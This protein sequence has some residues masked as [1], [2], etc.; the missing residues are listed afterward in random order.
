MAGWE[1]CW[2]APNN[3][4]FGFVFVDSARLSQQLHTPG[5]GELAPTH[6]IAIIPAARQ[7]LLRLRVARSARLREQ[8]TALGWRIIRDTDLQNWASQPQTTLT[9]LQHLLSLDPLAVQDR[10]QLSLI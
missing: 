7:D 3:E 5:D 6:K 4:S 10:T 8:L 9:D 2:R 1:L